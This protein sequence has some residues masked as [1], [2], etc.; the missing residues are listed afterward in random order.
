MKGNVIITKEDYL[1]YRIE[2]EILERL[3][4]GGVDDWEWYGESL[5]PEDRP[6]MDEFKKEM[7]ATIEKMV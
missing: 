2:S 5:N 6:D 7:R 3:N 4:E 1:V